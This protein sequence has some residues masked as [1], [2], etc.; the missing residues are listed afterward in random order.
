MNKIIRYLTFTFLSAMVVAAC[1]KVAD[2]PVYNDGLA[3]VVSASK[4][5]LSPA[6]ADSDRAVLT[7]NWTNP[8]YS[9]DAKTTKYIVQFDSAGGNFSSPISREVIGKLSTSYTGNELNNILLSYAGKPGTP[10]SLNV[11]VVSSYSNNNEKHISSNVSVSVTGFSEPNKLTS[12]KT[13]VTATA[14]TQN[15]PALTFDW[16]RA[17][18]SYSGTVTYAIEYD[19]LGKNFASP[20]VFDLPGATASKE[21]LVSEINQTVLDEGVLPGSMGKIQYRTKAMTALGAIVYSNAV[22]V[23]VSPSTGC[24]I[25]Y[26][27]KAVRCR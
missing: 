1:N 24:C 16:T 9:N 25:A 3:P 22:T 26:N 17:F 20:Q 18:K 5:A 14:A 6:L 23:A 13:S 19:S 10:Y 2:L 15:N 4:T 11:R 27:I 21:I 7:I 12:T 8:K